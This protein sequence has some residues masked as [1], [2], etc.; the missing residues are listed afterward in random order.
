MDLK[1]TIEAILF[2]AGRPVTLNELVK[3]T[4]GSKQDVLVALETLKTATKTSGVV[5]LE[6]NKKYLLSTHPG[7]SDAV[8]KIPEL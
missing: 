6:Q 7:A 5:L 1:Q 2:V 4:S 8:K 3:I